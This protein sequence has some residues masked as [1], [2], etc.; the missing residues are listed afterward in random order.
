[1]RILDL[2]I[3]FVSPYD[4]G[5]PG[6]VNNHIR[7]LATEFTRLGHEVR[8]LV[9]SSDR[10]P[11]DARV[12]NASSA[13]IP[14]PFA[15]SIA[16][17]SLD[18]RVYRRTKRI[19]QKGGYDVL[20]LHEPL[21][22]LLPLAVLR[23]HDLVP[24]AICVGTFHA[25]REVSRAY[26]YGAPIFRRFFKRLDG[27]ITVSEAAHQYH[28]RYFPAE[29]AVIPNGVDVEQFDGADLRPIDE[30]ADGRLNILFVGR[31]EKRKGLPYL[32]EAFVHVKREVPEARL[33]VVGA[34]DELEK[35]PFLLQVRHLGL[36]DVHFVGRVT[37]EELARYYHTA[38]VFC[39]PSTGMESFGIVL[40]EAMASGVPV[41]ASDIEGYQEVI[42]D[43]TQGVLVRSEDPAALASALVLLLRDPARRRAMS[44]AG[45]E[46]AQRYSWHIV[47][48]RVLEYYASVRE[49]V[50][51]ATA[52]AGSPVQTGAQRMEKPV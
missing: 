12:I 43:G 22:P 31:L 5:V 42:D 19:L 11:A 51:A 18:P 29:Y 15:G 21:M 46:K 50:R 27:H 6:G 26:Y 41:V 34:Y 30:F 45:R 9:P 3:A 25:Y 39:A 4:Y 36:T 47:A 35:V 10:A 13:I 33:I 32:I 20:H 38:D 16:H 1:L 44:A 23:H 24:Q 48:A 28:L 49:R 40:L 8:I 52:S 14:V 7:H 2:R 37:D 17:V